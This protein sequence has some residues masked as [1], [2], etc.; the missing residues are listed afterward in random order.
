M[1]FLQG[2][3]HVFEG[4]RENVVDW[5]LGFINDHLLRNVFFGKFPA[6]DD[7]LLGDVSLDVGDCVRVLLGLPSEDVVLLV[8]VGL[9]VA[10]AHEKA[11]GTQ[12]VLVA[13]VDAL[14]ARFYPGL[15]LF[16]WAWIILEIF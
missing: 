3:V 16:F 7:I 1:S 8:K 12:R 9:G 10:L 11:Q 2:R 15:F 4:P 13:V 6:G 5:C 14:W